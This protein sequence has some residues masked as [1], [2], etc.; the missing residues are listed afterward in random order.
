MNLLFINGSPRK[1]RRMLV[2]L[3]KFYCVFL[4][5]LVSPVVAQEKVQ[6]PSSD[7]LEFIGTYEDE[8]GSWIDP[9]EMDKMNLPKERNHERDKRQKKDESTH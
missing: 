4:L 5:C 9:A 3:K 6:Q 7:L 1:T 8:N 2:N